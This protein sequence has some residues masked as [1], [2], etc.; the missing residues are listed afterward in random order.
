MAD[1]RVLINEY[2]KQGLSLESPELHVTICEEYKPA[3]YLHDLCSGGEVL[4]QNV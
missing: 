2:V 1:T 4:A 3:I